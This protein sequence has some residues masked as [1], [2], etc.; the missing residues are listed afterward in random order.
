MNNNPVFG[1]FGLAPGRPVVKSINATSA[2][3]GNTDCDI[4][5]AAGSGE[6]WIVLWALQFHDDDGGNRNMQWRIND[7]VTNAGL[8]TANADA[9]NVYRQLYDVVPGLPLPIILDEDT[10]L[11]ARGV[12]L[13]AGH[14]VE[15]RLLVH[16]LEGM[17]ALE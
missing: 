13:V 14:K 6:V 11:T 3:A 10:R 15:V 12:D 8:N 4:G 2:G 16:V 9:A 7:Q 5:P 1:K 17:V